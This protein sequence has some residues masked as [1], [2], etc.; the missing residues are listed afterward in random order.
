MAIWGALVKPSSK[1]T[2]CKFIANQLASTLLSATTNLTSQ[3]GNAL[4]N[5]LGV[6]NLGGKPAPSRGVLSQL[7]PSNKQNDKK[8]SAS[9]NRGGGLLGIL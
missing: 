9:N 3:L 6:L 7:N 5:P 8:S 4:G 1:D 2:N